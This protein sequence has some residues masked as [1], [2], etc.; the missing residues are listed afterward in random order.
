MRKWILKTLLAG[1]ALFVVSPMTVRA[2]DEIRVVL[3]EQTL[4]FDV[5]PQIING[6]T[7]VP[8]A[9]IFEAFQAQVI[10]DSATQTITAHKVSGGE[11]VMTIGNLMFSVNGIEELMDTPPLIVDG[12]T[13]VPVRFVAQ[14]FNTEVVWDGD[15]NTV[16]MNSNPFIRLNPQPVTMTHEGLTW[17]EIGSWIIYYLYSGGVSELE[18]EVVRLVNVERATA[19]ALPLEVCPLLSAAARFKSQEMADLQYFAHESPL[20][21]PP[22]MIPMLLFD[23]LHFISENLSRRVE[24]TN[25]A[26]SIVED[27]MNSPGHRANML[28]PSHE[29]IGVGVVMAMGA[30]VNFDGS[31]ISD[32]YAALTTQM[33]GTHPGDLGYNPVLMQYIEIYSDLFG[34][35]SP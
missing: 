2:A 31:P 13:L 17:R 23:A 7:M 15:N 20:F 14:V 3:D 9:P 16:L 10:W 11:V 8:V 28:N 1:V 32:R 5:A 12:R 6:R 30:G 26:E 25:M 18:Y 34:V 27:L 29:V 19:G 4:R 21:G 24:V 22:T 35:V 33:F